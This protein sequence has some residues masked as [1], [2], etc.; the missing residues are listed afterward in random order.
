M[1]SRSCG[2]SPT[3]SL[4]CGKAELVELAPADELFA[5]PAH[6]YTKALLDAAL[7]LEGAP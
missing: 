6:E 2:R 1:T 4:S 7:E 5:A 3:G